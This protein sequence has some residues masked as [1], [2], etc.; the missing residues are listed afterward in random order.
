[1]ST[2]QFTILSEEGESV[3]TLVV[4]GD[5]KSPYIARDDHPNFKAIVGAALQGEFEDIAELFDI[6]DTIALKFQ[7][8]S[9]RV[10]VEDDA[11]YFDGVE[12]NS[13]LTQQI[14]AVLNSGATDASWTALV[15]FFENVQLNPS[16]RSR[17]QL[18]AW[19]QAQGESG[20][21]I[22]E[23]GFLVGYKGVANDGRG[24]YRSIN[25]GREKVLVDDVVC[26]GL[27]P[28]PLGATV[29]MSRDLVNDDPSVGC[30]VGLHVGTYAYASSWGHGVVLEVRVNPRDVV[31][32]PYDSGCAKV[33]ACRY[34]IVAPVEQKYTAP[35]LLADAPTPVEDELDFE[36]GDVVEISGRSGRSDRMGVVV[37]ENHLDASD[38]AIELGLVPVDVNGSVGHYAAKSLTLAADDD[39]DLDLAL[40]VEEAEEALEAAQ[41]AL[42]DALDAVE[43]RHGK[44]GPTSQEAKGRGLN[45][46]QDPT[47]GKFVNGRPGSPRNTSTGRFA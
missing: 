7:R 23:D 13:A 18:Y 38:F 41:E 47:T 19:I 36:P 2:I 27:I 43:A 16:E 3:I 25:S 17:E 26:T 9:E 30:H 35:V 20:L 11:V 22:D 34:T 31:A 24:G 14:L 37:S 12:V 1:M 6:A 39:E 45:P 32:V 29:E 8:L 44:G 46:A 33:R 21:T 10:T 40:E 28:Q 42:D 15:N 5:P 4:P